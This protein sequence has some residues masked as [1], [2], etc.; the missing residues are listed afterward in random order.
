MFRP[1]YDRAVIKADPKETVLE[2]GIILPDNAAEKPQMG[3]VQAVGLG[4]MLD[5]GSLQ[6]LQTKVGDRVLYGKYAGT[7][8]KVNG[9]TL[10]IMKESEIL[11]VL[12]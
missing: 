9:E 4:K 2:S 7:E 12:E 5:D 6:A 3:T 8:V 10:L 11:G 1:L